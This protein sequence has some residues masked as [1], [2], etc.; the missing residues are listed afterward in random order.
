M[1]G[2]FDNVPG[3]EPAPLFVDVLQIWEDGS[4]DMLSRVDVPFDRQNVLFAA[5][6]YSGCDAT[7]QDADVEVPENRDGELESV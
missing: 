3:P 7:R 2:L 4:D 1:T 5:V 6:S